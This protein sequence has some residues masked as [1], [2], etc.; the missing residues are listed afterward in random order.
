VKDRADSLQAAALAGMAE[1]DPGVRRRAFLTLCL[2]P[3]LAV[4]LLV[5]VYPL[6]YN[7][8]LSFSDASIYRLR[9]WKITGFNQYLLVF[10]DPE[11][12][13]IFSKTMVWTAV[14]TLLQIVIGLALAVVLHQHFIQGRSAWRLLLLLPWAMP[15]YI[16]ALTWRGMFHGETGAV[17]WF[18]GRTFGLPPVEWLTSPF[19]A[20]AAATLVNVWMGFPFMMI[21]AL[22]GL[23]GIPLGYYEAARLDG[24]SPWTQFTRLTAPLLKPVMLPAT[25][26]GIIWNFNNLNVIW[27]FS[28]GGEPSDSTHILVSYVYKTAFTYY[29]FGWSAALSVVI[30]VILFFAVQ[31]FLQINRWRR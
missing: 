16:T 14:S 3:A 8:I 24:A 22:A 18:L 7:I 5:M 31:T 17:N 23:R 12:W 1:W 6:V 28:N 19:E 21:V 30:F 25:T 11:F 20:F 13:I 15:Q 4:L 9:D 29:R 27:L 26:L 10:R 2:L